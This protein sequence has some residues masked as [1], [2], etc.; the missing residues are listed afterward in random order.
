MTATAR[1]SPPE[2][3]DTTPLRLD[4]AARVAFPDGGMSASSLRREA[5]RGNLAIERVAG[6]DFTTLADIRDMRAKCRVKARGPDY[7]CESSAP[8][9]E[10]APEPPSGSSRTEPG[11]LA[12]DAA[13][14]TALR[15]KQGW[16]PISTPNTPRPGVN[17]I[18]L[19][20]GL[21]T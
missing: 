9:P 5:E 21:R 8:E 18:S 14:A 11:K 20:L 10:V 3:G 17:V 12:L 19:K 15:L 7:G 4:V 13:K 1:P 6:K 2:I 16:P